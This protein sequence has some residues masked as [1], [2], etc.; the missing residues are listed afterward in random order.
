MTA[1]KPGDAVPDFLWMDQPVGSD[2]ANAKKTG[3]WH[4]WPTKE[5]SPVT[6]TDDEGRTVRI[7]TPVMELEGLITPTPLHYTVQHFAV[8]PVVASAAWQL[9][10]YGEVKSPLTLNFEQLRRSRTQ[11]PH[12]HGML[13]ERR[14]LLRV[15]QR[16]RAQTVTHARRHDP[17]RQRVDRRAASR[18]IARGGPNCEIAPCTRRGQRPRSAADGR[19]GAK[20]F[21]YDKGLPI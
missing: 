10:V 17:Q 1:V 13:R 3:N 6:L 5:V 11:R 18:G 4:G 20:P 8:P 12:R 19:R 14:D 21:Y 9:K 16:R 7:R 2:P 15:L